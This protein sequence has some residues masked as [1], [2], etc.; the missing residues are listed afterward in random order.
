MT[1]DKKTPSPSDLSRGAEFCGCMAGPNDPDPQCEE[2]GGSGRA[3]GRSYRMRQNMIKINREQT[4]YDLG[5]DNPA[6]SYK[7][8][9][10]VP[11]M[12]VVNAYHCG[13][14]DAQ[15]HAP[16]ASV[17]RAEDYDLPTCERKW[18]QTAISIV[19]V[20]DAQIRAALLAFN[21]GDMDWDTQDE[22]MMRLAL[23]AA[24]VESE[25]SNRTHATVRS[26]MAKLADMLDEDQF[27]ACEEIVRVAGVTPPPATKGIGQT[28]PKPSL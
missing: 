18:T 3:T 8:N 21:S 11:H 4:A 28:T 20:T 12:V 10:V 27:A 13:Q 24:F 5:Y 9:F 7:G 22:E 2:C 25:G 17:F 16:R 23:E 14:S 15:N 1:E 19:R 6:L 26:L